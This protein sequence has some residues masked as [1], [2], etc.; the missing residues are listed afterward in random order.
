MLRIASIEEIQGLQLTLPAIVNLFEKRD[1]MFSEAVK[2]WLL[3]VERVLAQNRLGAA[4]DLATLRATLIAA[5][6]GSVPAEATAGTRSARKARD[7]VAADVLRRADDIVT[8]LIRK[9]LA[10]IA[11]GERVAR[12]LVA[13]ARAK[14]MVPA[15]GAVISAV[16]KAMQADSDLRPSAIGLEGL[17]GV[18]D[19]LVLLDRALTP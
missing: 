10:Q 4:G 11:D 2:R 19:T 6:R 9:P 15:N 3:D 12:Q 17:M 16:W 1:P 8:G 5:Q 13:V 18:C 14:G 7:A